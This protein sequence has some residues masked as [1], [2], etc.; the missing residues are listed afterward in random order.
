MTADT[1]QLIE[2]LH[3]LGLHCDTLPLDRLCSATVALAC[4]P[5]Y[6]VAN[7]HAWT[8]D[9]QWEVPVINFPGAESIREAWTIGRQE[10]ELQRADIEMTRE[11]RRVLGSLLGHAKA[12]DRVMYEYAVETLKQFLA[13][14][15]PQVAGHVRAAVARMIVAVAKASGEGWFGTGEAV[16]PEERA[17]IGYIDRELE[18]RQSPAADEILK[19]L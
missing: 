13:V 15:E 8:K 6:K 9:R 4:F 7:V 17:S 14:C 16:S 19:T 5:M 3:K 10:G 18:L 11:H 12:P 1:T 2:R